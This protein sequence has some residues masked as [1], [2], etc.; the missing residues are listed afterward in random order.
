MQIFNSSNFNISIIDNQLV[1]KQLT[2]DITINNIKYL[3]KA[4]KTNSNMLSM[5]LSAV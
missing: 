1:I 5:V 2:N 4:F 3:L